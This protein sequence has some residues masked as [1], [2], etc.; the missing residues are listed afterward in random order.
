VDASYGVHHDMRS[1]TGGLLSLGK[2][3]IYALSTLQKL[4]AKSSTEAELVGVNDVLLWTKYLLQEQGY[5]CDES[6]IY[7]DNKA[8]YTVKAMAA[9]PAVC[10]L[11][12]SISDIIL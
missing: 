10:E 3:A 9:C 8:L 11:A 12:I 2:G 6:I 5:R 1:H 7:Q 4:N